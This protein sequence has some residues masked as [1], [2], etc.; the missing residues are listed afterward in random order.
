MDGWMMVQLTLG[1][2]HVFVRDKTHGALCH[3]MMLITL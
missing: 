1:T 2:L 3:S